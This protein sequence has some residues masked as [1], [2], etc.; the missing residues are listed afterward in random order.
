M[1]M[2][3]YYDRKQKIMTDDMAKYVEKIEGMAQRGEKTQ[4]LS[5]GELTSFR[6]LVM[7]MRWPC[8]HVMPEYMYRVSALAQRVSKANQEDVKMANVLLKE[9]KETAKRGG[10]KLTYRAV[11]SDPCFV[12]Y[13]DA[14]LGKK[15]DG[16]AQSGEVHLLTDMAATTTPR[17]ACII[18]FIATRLKE[19]SEARWLQKDVRWPQPP[20]S[21]YTADCCTELYVMDAWRFHPIGERICAALAL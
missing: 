7:K 3:V 19:L 21:S 1:G 2:T 9:M 12:S 13:F 17:T 16:T 20:T 11:V 10:A 6:Q 18:E 14:S 4:A 8:Q 15:G 5:P